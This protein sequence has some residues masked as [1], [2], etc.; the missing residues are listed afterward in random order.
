MKI[1]ILG[2]IHSNL[3]ALTSVV[4][5][6][7]GQGA[8]EYFSV[9][10][11]VGYGP[12]P[13]PC[14]QLLRDLQAKVIAGNHDWAVLGKIDINSFNPF[15]RSSILWTMDH[16][17]DSDL[18]FLSALPLTIETSEFNIVHGT[19]HSPESFYYMQSIFDAECTFQIMTRPVCF[20]G[21]SHV[22]I[23]FHMHENDIFY[24]QHSV[25][26]IDSK[27]HS[28]H[29]INVGSVGQPRNGNPSS[30]YALYDTN[31]SK[32][33]FHMVEYDLDLTVHKILASGLPEY[34]AERLRV[35]H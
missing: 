29:I 2:D 27:P 10:D 21:H 17:S 7:K 25:T 30:M 14:I 13:Q 28:K 6:A 11:V 5:H 4:H 32:V 35:G 18:E 1:A 20:C 3:E 24:D 34:N 19:L 16:L 33:F 8:S 12:D 23:N 22:P 26:Q 15:A 9:G 31:E